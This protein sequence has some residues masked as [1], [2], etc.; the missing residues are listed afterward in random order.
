MSP[1]VPDIEDANRHEVLWSDIIEPDQAA[2]DSHAA[3]LARMLTAS[4]DDSPEGEVA[5]DLRDVLAVAKGP[6]SL[7]QPSKI[8]NCSQA[9]LK[10]SAGPSGSTTRSHLSAT[11]I[12]RSCCTIRSKT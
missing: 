5:A 6:Q 2:T 8:K 7:R 10:S 11:Q 9:Q 4:A 12:Q 1:F 3:G